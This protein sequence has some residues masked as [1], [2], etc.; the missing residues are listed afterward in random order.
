MLK[1]F[2]K[3]SKNKQPL[4]F[5]SGPKD[6]NYSSMPRSEDSFRENDFVVRF[7][8]IPGMKHQMAKP[9]TFDKLIQWVE[10]NNPQ[11]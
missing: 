4:A 7:F 2:R 8:D 9:E 5:I 10:A 1:D 11:L 3:A 6:S